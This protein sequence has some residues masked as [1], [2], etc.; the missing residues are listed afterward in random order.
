MSCSRLVLIACLSCA[1]CTAESTTEIVTHDPPQDPTRAERTSAARPVERNVAGAVDEP[2]TVADQAAGSESPPSALG[3]D[4]TTRQWLSEL[5]ATDKNVRD[6]ASD[7]LAQVGDD[8]LAEL[9]V[10]LL[11]DPAAEVRR[12]A[13]F[14]LLPLF[15]PRDPVM[16]AAV[17]KA[18][19]DED[20]R[21]RHIS[22][23]A[24]AQLEGDQ[25]PL[26][27]TALTARLADAQ[28]D[29]QMQAEVVRLL[30]RHGPAA[31]DALPSLLQ[32]IQHSE[33][34]HLRAACLR[35]TT[36]IGASEDELLPTYRHV[37]RH[38]ADE[39]LRVLAAE[40]ISAMG[41]LAEPAVDDLLAALRDDS[42]AVQGVAADA[43]S[44][45]GPPALAQLVK[46][47]D[48]PHHEV[49]ILAIY[50]AGKMGPAAASITARLGSLT[51]DPDPDVRRI[52]ELSLFRV[53]G[54]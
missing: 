22:L 9:C 49:R 48:S 47:F 36:R 54:G 23:Q 50:A 38:D 8:R 34:R 1:G 39:R 32:N 26:A 6:A 51:E 46:L 25:A 30:G 35:A 10:E 53:R 5:T 2:L 17:I 11:F 37:L 16:V 33:V 29:A 20:R 27:I 7:A 4:A 14:A 13:A 18:L 40:G 45:I 21:V 24:V 44:A 43:L 3:A 41:P 52:A 15:D 42:A 28:E 12:G 19:Q 31:H